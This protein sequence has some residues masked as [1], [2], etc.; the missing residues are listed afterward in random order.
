MVSAPCRRAVKR[1][2]IEEALDDHRYEDT[3]DADA[4]NRLGGGEPGL[5]SVEAELDEED[6]PVDG[7]EV[8]LQRVGA[9]LDGGDSA[10]KES[11]QEEERGEDPGSRRGLWIRCR[12]CSDRSN[13]GEPLD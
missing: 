2:A 6:A 13:F 5:Q 4:D 12:C 10:V 9:L 1:S 7:V 11:G 8:D 3:L